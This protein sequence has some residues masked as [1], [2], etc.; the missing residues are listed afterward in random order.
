MTE[1]N[2]DHEKKK[3]R[4]RYDSKRIKA[5]ISCITNGI[6]KNLNYAKISQE[7]YK[8]IGGN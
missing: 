7:E 4:P 3:S 5:H 1:L 8:R 6:K 2:F